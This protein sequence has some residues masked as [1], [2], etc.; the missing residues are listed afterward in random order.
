MPCTTE[1]AAERRDDEEVK[2]APH[3]RR[4]KKTREAA[5]CKYKNAVPVETRG[6]FTPES[7]GSPVD[8]ANDGGGALRHMSELQWE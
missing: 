6:D 2:S 5:G 7:T 3:S 4:K 8:R 1:C